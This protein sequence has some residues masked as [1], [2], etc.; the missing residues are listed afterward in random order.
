MRRR[1]NLMPLT[2]DSLSAGLK[3]GRPYTEDAFPL[4]FDASPAAISQT[5]QTALAMG[6]L[7]ASRQMQG[8]RR[9]YWIPVEPNPNVTTRRWQPGDMH[10]QLTGYDLMG[11]ARLAM[12]SR[13]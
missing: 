1:K 13:R 6:K 5:I 7:H 4:I 10:G 2:L 8:F 11:F 3:P 9:T 12:A